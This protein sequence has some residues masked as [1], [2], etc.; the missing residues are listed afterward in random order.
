MIKQLFLSAVFLLVCNVQAQD[1]LTS[2]L[3]ETYDD[4][5]ESSIG[6]RRIKHADIQPLIEKFKANPKF[7]VQKNKY[8]L[9]SNLFLLDG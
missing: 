8:F 7:E 3:Y 4:Y 2:K 9:T 6:K 5:K 1:E